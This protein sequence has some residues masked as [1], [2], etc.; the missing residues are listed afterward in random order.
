MFSIVYSDHVRRRMAEYGVSEEE[1]VEVVR[2]GSLSPAKF[3]R[4]ARGKAAGSPGTTGEVVDT[5]TRK[6]W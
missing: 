2:T 4:Q 5:P 6:C 3:N 1:V